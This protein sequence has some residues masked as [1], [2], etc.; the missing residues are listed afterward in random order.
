MRIGLD[1]DNTIVCYNQ[2]FKN[3]AKKTDLI[4]ASWSGSKN[5]LRDYL[6]KQKNGEMSWQKLQGQ[7][8]GKYMYQATMFPGLADFLVQCLARNISIDIVSH[9]T[10]YGHHDPEKIPLRDAA[11]LWLEKQGF[12]NKFKFGLSKSNVWFKSTRHEK[13]R[14]VFELGCT[15]FVD[16][17]AE[18]FTETGF[19]NEVEKYL[20]VPDD[21]V[22]EI[23]SD[24]TIVTSWDDI[25]RKIFED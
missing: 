2:V 7:V 16:D 20:F 12:F 3:I 1:L 19:P 25:A 8:Y 5:E 24:I 4:D 18:V 23:D 21:N 13:V 9:K 17:L 6:R 10:K 14:K 11:L 15:H 22:D